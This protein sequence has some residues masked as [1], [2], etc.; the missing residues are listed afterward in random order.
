MSSSDHSENGPIKG[1]DPSIKEQIHVSGMYENW[2][3]DY[4]SYV[5]L[6]RAVPA[7]EDGVK[8]VQRRILHAMK[9]M[10]DGR[11]HK[12][13]NII[14]QTMQY[15]P[16]GDAAIGDALV[17]MGQKDLLIET[18]GNWGDVRT[19]D[20]AA[21][22]RYIEAKLSSF[23]LEVSF[24]G[25]NTEWQVSYDGR[26]K[27]PVNLPMKFP[28]VLA[29]GVEGIAVGLAT[30]IMPHNFVELCQGSIQVLKGK[31]TKILPDFPTGG[32]ADF[33]DYNRGLRGG[34]I[35][36]RAVIEII[37]KK[38]LA[39]RELPFN[40]TTTSIIDSI[41]KANDKG[42]IKI[43]KVVDNTAA[44]VEILIELASGVS[45]DLSL[46]ALFAFTLCEQS[47]SPNACIIVEDK[48]QFLDVD[49][50]LKT[51]TFNTRELLKREL[52]IKKA[53]LEEKWH[54]ASL[55]RIFIENR[56]YRDIETSETWEEVI[57][58]I[59]KG[60]QPFKKLLKREVT[61]EDIVR[62]TEIKIKRIS[63]FDSFR[64]EDQILKLE[65]QIKEIEQN[66]AN[67]TD[68]TIDYFQMLIAKFGKGKERK[69]VI[70]N[71]DT[72]QAVQVVANNA[73]LYTNLAEGF[74]GTALKKDEFVKECSDIDDVIAFR[75]DGNMRVV[76]IGDKVFVGGKDII[77]VD[78]WKKGDDRTTYNLIYRDGAR[79]I[80]YA[81]RFAA[82]AITRDKD[83]K[84]TK[85]NEKDKILYFTANPNGESETVSIFLSNGSRARKKI[86]EFDFADLDIKGRGSKGNIVTRYPVR[87]VE[88]KELGA[89]TIGGRKI[90]LDKTVGRLNT[91]SRGE[92]LGEFDTGDNI[93]IINK[94][95]SY[96]L[97][98][99]E[100]TNR[101]N[102]NHILLIEKFDI[103]K[104]VSAVYYDGERRKFFIKRFYIETTSISQAFYFISEHNQS[105]I[106]VVSTVDRLLIE[107]YELKG[108]G[109]EWVRV[110]LWLNEFIDI[111]GW[112]SVGNQLGDKKTVK[113]I[114]L[115]KEESGS[116]KDPIPEGNPDTGTQTPDDGLLPG[117][118]IEW[119]I[120]PNDTEESQGNLFQ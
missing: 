58:T 40:T 35:R 53:A 47:I 106:A 38:T 113:K 39:I 112:K 37:D 21:A 46:D 42:K 29:M 52:E 45:P 15:H 84:L 36:V 98:G 69:T 114:K 108:Q 103:G 91:D 24:N 73:K 97:T 99:F 92:F 30:K 51:S 5:I 93:L 116:P 57:N 48:P 87:K 117:S 13:A 11:F 59:D 81:K 23:A 110:E 18:Q 77:H 44:D 66:L 4:A 3:L 2:F 101:Y 119:D 16:H 22:A 68:Y 67:L 94:D 60:L 74:I 86:F 105:A 49:T 31:N 32:Q 19:G 78:T 75:K 14:G 79:G 64:A 12:V 41:L 55:E 100:I 63:K 9:E 56:I 25:D 83:Y 17:N 109:K 65:E 104:P 62:L 27:E 20:S 10:D 26:K 82:T 120:D 28:L 61:E 95:G 76:R 107:Y 54:F 89:S 72:I 118:V 1:Q 8:P 6:E 70:T 43:K 102:M 33:S 90:W 115:L 71:F 96:E 7:L 111:K 34:K 50:V 80:T 85:G 88:Q